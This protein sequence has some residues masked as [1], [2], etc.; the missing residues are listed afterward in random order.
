[1]FVETEIDIL[2]NAGQAISQ[3][4]PSLAIDVGFQPEIQVNLVAR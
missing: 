1:L 4:V 3:S 2:D